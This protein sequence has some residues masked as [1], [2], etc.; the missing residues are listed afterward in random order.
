[1][2]EKT[3]AEEEEGQSFWCRYKKTDRRDL[4]ARVLGKRERERERKEKKAKNSS[5]RLFA[6]E[7]SLSVISRV[8]RSFPRLSRFFFEISNF[9]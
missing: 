2:F 8:P 1:M 4:V 6:R 9:L 5:R 7:R 3:N